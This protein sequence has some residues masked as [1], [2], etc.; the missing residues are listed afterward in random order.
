MSTR[1]TVA[2]ARLV[3]RRDELCQLWMDVT[4]AGGA[5]G[6]R[7]PVTILDVAPVVDALLGELATGPTQ[8]IVAHQDDVLAG[9]V[10]VSPGT[11]ARHHHRVT[12]RRLLVAPSLQRAGLGSQLVRAAEG[13]ARD[14]LDAE[15]ALAWVRDGLGLDRFY[16]R[17]GYHEAGRIPGGLAFEDGDRVDDLLYVRTLDEG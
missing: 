11:G 10:A 3:S 16:T 1:L 15:L 4:A 8:V 12:L 6:F 14:R 7:P 17:L 2:D 5:V 9:L 13:R